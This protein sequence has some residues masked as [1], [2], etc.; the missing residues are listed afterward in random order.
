MSAETAEVLR[1]AKQVLIDRGW[2][3]VGK[4]EDSAGCVC[5][6]GA[7]GVAVADD[8]R[9]AAHRFYALGDARDR[10]DLAVDALESV[11]DGLPEYDEGITEWNDDQLS[12]GS[13]LAVFDRAIALAEAEAVPA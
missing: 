6:L 7:I 3:N 12:V 4:F 10:F 11:V 9:I 1:K 5:S 13:V 8:P 2:T